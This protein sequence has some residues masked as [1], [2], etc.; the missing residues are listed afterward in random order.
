MTCLVLEVTLELALGLRFRA[1]VTISFSFGSLCLQIVV[2]QKT[3]RDINLIEH[4]YR[5]VLHSDNINIKKGT[6]SSKTLE[7]MQ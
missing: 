6:C 5:N 2:E 3:L 4:K 1:K 7:S